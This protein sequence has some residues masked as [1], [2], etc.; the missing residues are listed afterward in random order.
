MSALFHWDLPQWVQDRGGWADRAVIGRFAEYADAV[1]RSLGDRVADDRGPQPPDARENCH[2][3]PTIP[4]RHRRGSALPC[5]D[6]SHQHAAERCP[7]PGVHDHASDG[8]LAPELRSLVLL[9]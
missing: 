2:L 9:S 7:G 8:A 5:R 3:E 4:G 6:V 1:V